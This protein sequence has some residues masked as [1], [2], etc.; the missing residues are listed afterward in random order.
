MK[1]TL[2]HKS[3]EDLLNLILEKKDLQKKVDRRLLYEIKNRDK[4]SVGEGKRLQALYQAGLLEIK[5]AE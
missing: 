2:N 5:I 1:R 4:R 3:I